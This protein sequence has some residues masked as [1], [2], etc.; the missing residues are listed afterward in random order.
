MN[1]ETKLPTTCDTITGEDKGRCA[2]ASC[3]ASGQRHPDCAAIGGPTISR[4]RG[5]IN[6]E[7]KE[8]IICG[9]ACRGDMTEHS[10]FGFEAACPQKPNVRTERRLAADNQPETGAA[11]SR[12]LQ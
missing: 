8:C 12:P 10:F 7:M 6:D 5:C 1:E 9:N 11:P 4:M 3:S 2:P